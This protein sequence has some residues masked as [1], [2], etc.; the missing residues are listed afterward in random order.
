M[1]ISTEIVGKE[2]GP[3]VRDYDF[4]DL[5]IC[6]LGCGAAFDGKTDL[7][8]VNEHDQDN[9]SL[10]VLPIFGVPLTVNEK[11]TKTLD[12]GYNYAGSLHYGFDIKFLAPFKMAD[13][14]ETY[15]TQEALYD[16]GEGRGSLS[17]QVG[18]SYSSDGTLL[19]VTETEDCCIYDGGWGGE[20]PPKDIVEMPD[21]PADK[22]VEETFPLNQPLIYRLMGDWHQQH[23]DWEYTKQTGLERPIAH[24][25]SYAGMVM[26]HAIAS[27]I[28]HEPERLTRFKTRVTSPLVPGTKLHTKL[29]QV[30]DKE[31]RF[32]LVDADADETGA[33]P[34]LNYGIIEWK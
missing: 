30:G 2:F 22:V 18:R 33:K 5:E 13:H 24:A 4:K 17:V 20:K 31:L 32:Q 26:R 28:P 1:A 23:I 21:R 7:E 29:W 19:C 25:I 27:Y 15:V 3:F 9:P 6:A 8:Y 10:K 11:M 16:R 34:H 14:V 12:Y